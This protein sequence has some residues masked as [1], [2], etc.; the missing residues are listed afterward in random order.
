MPVA[1]PVVA[2]NVRAGS[3]AVAYTG[4]VGVPAGAPVRANV[5]QSVCIAAV[6]ASCGAAAVAGAQ[7][8]R[9]KQSS[10]PENTPL[11]SSYGHTGPSVL[12][13]ISAVG[14]ANAAGGAKRNAPVGGAAYDTPRYAH[15]VPTIAPWARGPVPRGTYATSWTSCGARNA[16][17]C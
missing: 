16:P 14:H 15:V 5:V 1:T 9:C 13:S 4:H 10:S 8:L 6:T 11:A 7:T 17:A 2:S 3:V 12:A